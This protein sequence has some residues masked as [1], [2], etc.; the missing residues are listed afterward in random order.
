MAQ[1]GGSSSFP[2][3]MDEVRRVFNM[4]DAN[5][6]GKISY[7]EV[8]QALSELGR[9]TATHEEATHKFSEIDRN[10]DGFIDVHEFAE[11]LTWEPIEG[12]SEEEQLRETFNFYD[13]D[14]DGLISAEELQAL[15][16]KFGQRC[17]MRDCQAMILT[18]DRDG[19]GQ[20]DFDDFK[21]KIFN[22]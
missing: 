9:T 7:D 11:F 6:D 21:A 1:S 4:Y 20:I 2:K 8:W 17:S 10:G 3:T 16:R 13:L 18:A 5:S 19:D 12:R 22:K 14:K 15:M